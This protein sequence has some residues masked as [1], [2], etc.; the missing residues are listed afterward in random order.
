M[1][2]VFKTEQEAKEYDKQVTA[3]EKYPIKGDNWSTPLKHATLNKWAVKASDKLV[4]KQ[5]SI[6][7]LSDDWFSF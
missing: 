7:V 1:Y 5:E 4:I 3:I 2:Y 6:N